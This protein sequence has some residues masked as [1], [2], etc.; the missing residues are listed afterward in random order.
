MRLA[1]LVP[2]FLLS[3]VPFSPISLNSEGDLPEK[4]EYRALFIPEMREVLPAPRERVELRVYNSADYISEDPDI[5]QM[6]EDYVLE[7]DG[8]ELEVIYET[9]DTN[10]TML[11]RVETGAAEYDLICPSDYMIQRMMRRGMLEPFPSGEEKRLSY[12]HNASEEDW[13]D[14]YD[15]YCSPFLEEWFEKIVGVTPDGESHPIGEYAKGYMWGTLGFTYNPYYEEYEARG[16]SPEEVKVHLT[17]WNVLLDERYQG[18]Y[19][20]KD[21]MRDTYSVALMQSYDEELHVLRDAYLS[22]E[23]ADG[24]PYGEEEYSRDVNAIF[25]NLTR[26]DEFNA[27]LERI[28]GEEAEEETVDSILEKA[29]ASL[30]ALFDNSYGL[31]VDSGKQDITVGRS[32]IGIAWSGD[33]VY[34]IELGEIEEDV[35][36]YYSVPK[37][38]GNIWFDGWVMQKHEGLNVEYAQKFVDFLSRPDVSAL[39]MDYIGYTPFGAGEEILSLVR[40]WYDARSYAMYVYIDEGD[41]DNGYHDFLYDEEGNPVF[42]DGTGIHEEVVV[43]GVTYHDV[44]FGAYD[45]EGSGLDKAVRDGEELSWESYF[46]EEEWEARP[47]DLGYFFEG[48]VEGDAIIWTDEL[49]EVTATNLLGEEETVLVGRGF[50]AQYPEMEMLPSLAVM[51]DYGDENESVLRIWEAVK[52]DSLEPWVIAVLVVEVALIGGGIL[53]SWLLKRRSRALRKARKKERESFSKAS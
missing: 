22:G 14:Y 15:S 47:V 5:I 3:F 23:W 36:L 17:D 50:Y 30:R 45:M 6:F 21:S 11:S 51:E 37:T 18:T 2:L 32:G 53:A 1:V 27:L 46:L 13:P 43:D 26:V 12:A 35:S 41:Y 31:E 34:S 9:F 33:A 42:Q 44:D 39:N 7:K 10:E 4:T 29:E 38:G 20:I 24:T 48:T 40:S 8:V 16:L 49:E 19:Q 52:S 28:H 25:N